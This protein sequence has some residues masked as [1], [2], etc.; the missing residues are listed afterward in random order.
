MVKEVFPQVAE[1]KIPSQDFKLFC[2][3]KC[4]GVFMNITRM[5]HFVFR[6]IKDNRG[7]ENVR[8]YRLVDGSKKRR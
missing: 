4:D 6:L 7:V 8:S 1:I 3:D 2:A 5:F